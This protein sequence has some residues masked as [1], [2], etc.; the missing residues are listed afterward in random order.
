MLGS[1]GRYIKRGYNGAKHYLI[2]VPI[3][4]SK[5]AYYFSKKYL[6]DI[7]YDYVRSLIFKFKKYPKQGESVPIESKP[8]DYNPEHD[9]LWTINK[10][11]ID[12]ICHFEGLYLKSY[13]DPVG[14]ATIGYGTIRYPSGDK[15]KLGQSCTKEQAVEWL[16]Y[17][18]NEKAL[19]IGRYFSSIGFIPN[20][21][22]FSA[23]VS[24]VY[25]LGEG[26]ILQPGRTMGNAIRA[27]SRVRIASSFL[28]YNKAGGKVLNGLVRRRDAE[29]ALFLKP[30]STMSKK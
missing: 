24:F 13:L 5:D 6:F 8:I 20:E 1:I 11:G 25:N 15:V 10:A 23:L 9:K 26:T 18:V 29:R 16:M 27:H 12:L 7:P 21:N 28:V 4:A 19:K 22:E 17:E 30:V 3:S 2:D 14:I